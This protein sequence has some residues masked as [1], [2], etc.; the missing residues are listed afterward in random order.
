MLV[1]NR[2]PKTYE[3]YLREVVSSLETKG[4]ETIRAELPDYA[5]PTGLVSRQDDTV[6]VPDITAI[7]HG[8]KYYFE[9]ARKTDQVAKLVGKWKLLAKLAA[10]K[11]GDFAIFVPR[12]Q[13]AFT[14]QI[15]VSNNIQAE[16][17]KM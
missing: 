6:Y 14:R 13:M 11:N 1:D 15:I 8:S 12:G 4:Y 7:R 5:P 3:K 10:L 16:V 2:N 9:I 17:H